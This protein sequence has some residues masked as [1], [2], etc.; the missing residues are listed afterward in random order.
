MK[1]NIRIISAAALAVI[2]MGGGIYAANVLAEGAS[3]KVV[4]TEVDG[5]KPLNDLGNIQE[6]SIIDDSDKPIELHDAD[7]K[8]GETVE[9]KNLTR[10][11]SLGNSNM[12]FTSFN[13]AESWAKKKEEQGKIVSY[14][15][16]PILWSDNIAHS[17]TVD[18]VLAR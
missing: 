4:K 12:E 5:S 1:S 3:Q 10:V 11:D 16:L 18:V 13:E 9:L 8:V 14:S 15:I 2:V 7:E 6:K 17:Y